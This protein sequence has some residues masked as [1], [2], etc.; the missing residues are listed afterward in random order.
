[1]SGLSLPVSEVAEKI[2]RWTKVTDSG[3]QVCI[4]RIQ[5]CITKVSL[6]RNDNTT[7]ISYV[8]ICNHVS[9]YIFMAVS[10]QLLT[11]SQTAP[12]GTWMSWM[13]CGVWHCLV[14]AM[15]LSDSDLG[16]PLLLFR[17]EN[18][19]QLQT[20]SSSAG[21]RI[22]W[23]Y[24]AA[25]TGTFSC[26]ISARK[27][28]STQWQLFCFQQNMNI[29]IHKSWKAHYVIWTAFS[30]KLSATLPHIPLLVSDGSDLEFF[31]I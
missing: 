21:S 26:T 19:E 17:R 31:L 2:C 30:L 23:R 16:W 3:L 15:T 18:G 27:W 10:S 22:F 1:M 8:G 28:Q 6:I 29:H 12:W 20:L 9:V 14:G 25:G 24:T 5:G 11:D 4:I 13:I 7:W